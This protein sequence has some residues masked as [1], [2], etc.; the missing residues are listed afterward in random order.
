MTKLDG[1]TAIITG[2]ASGMGA[3]TAR[4]Y[5]SEG[6]RVMLADVNEADGKRVADELGSAA[7]FQRHDVSD[8]DSWSGLVSACVE[9]FGDPGVLVNAAGLLRFC[10]LEHCSLEEYMN[11]VNVNQVGTMLGM[12]SVIPSMRRLGTGSIVNFSS[13]EGL[14]ALQGAVAYASTKFAIRGMTKVAALELGPDA[15]RVNSIHPGMVDT[16]MIRGVTGGAEIDY[17]PVNNRVA[18]RRMGK[19]EDIAAMAAFLGSDDSAF[20]TGA[21]FVVDGGATATHVFGANLG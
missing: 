13:I 5:V 9:Q 1:K 2:G 17:T 19:P 6:A 7:A 21:E 12:R 11:L 14:G 20:S 10:M 16:P 18:L 8:E 15:I 4:R 3:A